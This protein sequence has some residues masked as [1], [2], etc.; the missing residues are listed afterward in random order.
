MLSALA[1]E[2]AKRRVSDDLIADGDRGANPP[3]AM[4]TG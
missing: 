4:N 3:A 1:V 2:N